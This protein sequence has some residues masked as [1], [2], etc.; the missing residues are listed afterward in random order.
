M[1]V[2]VLYT[3]SLVASAIVGLWHASVTVQNLHDGSVLH[4]L[5]LNLIKVL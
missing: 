2:V 1:I 5:L 3:I 4:I